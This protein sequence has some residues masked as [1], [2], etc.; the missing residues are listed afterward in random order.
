MTVF[1][2]FFAELLTMRYGNFGGSHNHSHDQ[3]AG[4]ASGQELSKTS[5]DTPSKDGDDIK[6]YHDDESGSVTGNSRHNPHARG[7]DHL[8]HSREHRTNEALPAD[9]ERAGFMPESY[10]AQMTAI[11]ILEFGVIFHSIFI[12]LTLAVAG[13][14]FTTRRHSFP[15]EINKESN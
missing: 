9:W 8:G 5:R 4:L 1:A 12:G 14:E 6:P 7:E 3:E 2:L 13:E 10:A 15:E 11:F